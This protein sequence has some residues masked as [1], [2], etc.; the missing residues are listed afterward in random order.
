M[1][2]TE[3]CITNYGNSRQ[4]G[5]GLFRRET[6]FDQFVGFARGGFPFPVANGFGCGLRQHWMSTF[7]V[8]SLDGAIGA[9]QRV[10]SDHSIEGQIARQNWT[11]RGGAIDE[12]ARRSL[13]VRVHRVQEQHSGKDNNS[14]RT[15]S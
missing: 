6:H 15:L 10:N 13:G 7:H 14:D 12:F 8:H 5:R 9:D 1:K 4:N 11:S 2:I 3:I